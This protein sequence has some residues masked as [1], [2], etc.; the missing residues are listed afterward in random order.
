MPHRYL[1][2]DSRL[3]IRIDE[4]ILDHM[5]PI[6]YSNI[7]RSAL[8]GKELL[9]STLY[10]N[11]VRFALYVSKEKAEKIKDLA[12]TSGR[13]VNK[14]INHLLDYALASDSGAYNMTPHLH[15]E[16][17]GGHRFC[18]DVRCSLNEDTIALTNLG[19]SK[20]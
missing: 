16:A 1:T 7:Y 9:M 3:P 12:A 8:R 5:L 2:H 19:T 20:K 4:F 18:A 10:G 6:L 17:D 14:L 11:Q 13:P 15:A